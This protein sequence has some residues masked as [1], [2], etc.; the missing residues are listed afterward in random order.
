M[1][2]AFKIRIR[3]P[4]V[5]LFAFQP[6]GEKHQSISFQEQ[7]EL[8]IHALSRF[9]LWKTLKNKIYENCGQQ[10]CDR[11]Y[12][13][14]RK[15]IELIN[16]SQIVISSLPYNIPF[17]YHVLARC[18]AVAF[19]RFNKLK[20]I[21]SPYKMFYISKPNRT[22]YGNNNSESSALEYSVVTYP[23]FRLPIFRKPARLYIRDSEDKRI[24]VENRFVD[25]YIRRSTDTNYNY[26][27]LSKTD[28]STG[29]YYFVDVSF[30]KADYKMLK[31][32]FILKT[33]FNSATYYL[34]LT[35][36]YGLGMHAFLR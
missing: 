23:L 13:M 20:T 29:Q 18:L 17:T 25:V 33:R 9:Q 26:I 1:G 5:H 22:W 19:N 16:S 14:I 3:R 31:T 2:N 27:L 11:L 36:D 35:D 15:G 6:E 24:V 32:N 30:Y 12:K 8:V 4:H 21:V 10:D 34:G 7:Y 28:L